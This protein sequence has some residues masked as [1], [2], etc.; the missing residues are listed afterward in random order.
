[1]R[2]LC[3]YGPSPIDDMRRSPVQL[4]RIY[5][6]T[7]DFPNSSVGELALLEAYVQVCEIS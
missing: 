1:M 5:C 3:L 6:R 2:A 4:T 7:L